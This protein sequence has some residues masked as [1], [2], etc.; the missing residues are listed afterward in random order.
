MNSVEIITLLT[1]MQLTIDSPVWLL[2]NLI[3]EKSIGMIAGPRGCGKSF[4]V[5]LIAY[6]IVAK[7]PLWPWGMGSGATVLYLDGEMRL[8]TIQERLRSIHAKNSNPDSIEEFGNRFQI[9]SRDH[10]SVSIGSIDSVEGQE[11]I[12][13]L[14]SPETKLVLIDNISACTNSGS[15]NSIAWATTKTWLI[16]LRQKGISVLLVH[17]AGKNGQQRGS[18][19]HEDLLDYSILLSPLPSSTD[20]DD[21]RFSIEHTKLREHF[22]EL[23]QKYECSIWTEEEV[24]RHEIVPMATQLSDLVK[25]II[26]LSGEG[27]KQS[28][29]AIRLCVNKS[30]VSRALK[31]AR[32]NPPEAPELDAD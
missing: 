10:A 20:R 1:L 26:R 14:I 8:F 23:R 17:H 22:P 18:S 30:T 27:L 4:L 16:K 21:T 11:Q 25:E 5:M 9:I 19:A 2:G 6:A 3:C 13:K 24:L 29:I 31:E 12:E 15:E 7:K 32:K 28:E